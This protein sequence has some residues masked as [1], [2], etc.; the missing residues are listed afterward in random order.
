MKA[1]THTSL[2]P[3]R[4]VSLSIS[5]LFMNLKME[6]NGLKDMSSFEHSGCMINS[7]KTADQLQKSLNY[8]PL[9]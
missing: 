5:L 9:S 4:S 2:S 8:I 7:R 3:S 1:T 6:N